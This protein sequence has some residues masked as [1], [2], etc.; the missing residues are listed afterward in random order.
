MMAALQHAKQLG[1][2]ALLIYCDSRVVVDQL[3]SDSVNPIAPILRLAELF[4][5]LRDRLMTFEK[6]SVVWIPRHCNTE[7]DALAR[8]AAGLA[9]K[10]SKKSKKSKTRF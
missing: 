8:A 9:P 10:K 3:A 4:D 7:A 6:V 2:E 5:E 1:A